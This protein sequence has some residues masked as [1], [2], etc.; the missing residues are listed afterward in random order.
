MRLFLLLSFCIL[1]F[2]IFSQSKAVFRG[3]IYEKAT[4]QPISFASVVLDNTKYYSE[5]DLNGFF[6][7]GELPSGTYSVTISYLGFKDLKFE[8][9]VKPGEILYDRYYLESQDV[10]LETVEISGK[11]E[12]ARSEVSI[13]KVSVTPK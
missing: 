9:T 11:R 3:N 1:P 8:I 10:E 13:S 5:S 4:A 2:Y 7:I 6:A 12:Q